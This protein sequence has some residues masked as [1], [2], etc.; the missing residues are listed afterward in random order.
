MDIAIATMINKDLKHC[1]T[2]TALSACES[3]VP[4]LR[5]T[6]AQISQQS[7]QRQAE[8]AQMLNQKGIYVAPSAD[9]ATISVLAPQLRSAIAGIDTTGAGGA[10]AGPGTVGGG[11]PPGATVTAPRIM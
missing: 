9:D 8:L 10:W 4:E 2:S 11:H 6:L 5:S 3:T 7:I 1:A